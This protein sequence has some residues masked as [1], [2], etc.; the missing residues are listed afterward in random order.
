MD[1]S[2]ISDCRGTLDE[3][4]GVVTTDPCVALDF[5]DPHGIF[6]E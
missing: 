5:R 4:T 6:R 3:T 1:A 2:P